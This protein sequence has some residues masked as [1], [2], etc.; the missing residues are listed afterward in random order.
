[1]PRNPGKN[2]TTLIA[3]M[4]LEG[5]MGPAA[6]AAVEGGTDW[7]VVFEAYVERFLA[8]SP[9]A[10]QRSLLLDNER[11][12]QDRGVR[13]LVESRGCEVWFLPPYSPDMN[14]IEE[15]F[16]KA[17]ALLKKVSPPARRRRRSRPSRR[18]WPP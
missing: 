5:A 17:K 1:V 18:R 9:C 6:M 15:A 2:N 13:E 10:G 14:P 3:S 4:T 7:H 8:P 16:S 11:G 12:A